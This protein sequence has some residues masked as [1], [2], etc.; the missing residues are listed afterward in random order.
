MGKICTEQYLYLLVFIVCLS[1][2]GCHIGGF[3][4]TRGECK[5][6]EVSIGPKWYNLL[7]HKNEAESLKMIQCGRNIGICD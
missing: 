7:F 4:Q 6:R 3:G 2:H 5:H 1:L